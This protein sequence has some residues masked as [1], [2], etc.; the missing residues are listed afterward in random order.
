MWGKQ[1][2]V[3]KIR[4]QCWA[5]IIFGHQFCMN[6]HSLRCMIS[7]RDLIYI[8]IYIYIYIWWH[9]IVEMRGPYVVSTILRFTFQKQGHVRD[10]R[11]SHKYTSLA[12]KKLRD[13]ILLRPVVLVIWQGQI[14]HRILYSFRNSIHVFFMQILIIIWATFG[15]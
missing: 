1:V 4:W 8:Y 6:D 7:R 15:E 5:V 14:Q 10:L 9:I 2:N 11:I 3:C 12:C 13:I